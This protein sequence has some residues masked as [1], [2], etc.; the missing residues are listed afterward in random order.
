MAKDKNFYSYPHDTKA[1][2]FIDLIGFG[3][4]TKKFKTDDRLAQLVFVS[5]ENC[6]LYHRKFMK[7]TA[8]FKR[9][10]PA[11]LN[12]AGHTQGFWYSE[13]PDGSVNFVYLSDSVVMYST[14]ISHLIRELSSIFG[15]AII[16]AVP[17]RAVITIGDLEHS[18]W[19]ERPGSAICL[20]G[21]ALTKAVEIEKSK[22]GKSMR[23]WLDNDVVEIMKSVD[24]LKGLIEPPG[25]L[26]KH[27]ELKW[28][29][30]A[31]QGTQGR[32]ES[33]EIAH[34]YERWYSEKHTKGW[35]VGKNKD[36]TDKII[37]HAVKD[38]QGLGR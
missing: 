22:S 27:A 38:L 11:N 28:W 17:M 25:C 3:G 16:W 6:I 30:G 10:V 31:L 5:H 37:S 13:I 2:A 26:E 35:F 8:G 34:R 12:E 20:Y 9:E 4:L 18:E 32:N 7:E 21:S 36:D 1:I 29:L 24:G 33:Q 14:S 23:V 15:S 19:I